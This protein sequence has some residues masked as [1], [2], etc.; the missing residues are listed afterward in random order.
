[1]RNG[2]RISEIPRI[3]L[4]AEHQWIDAEMVTQRVDEIGLHVFQNE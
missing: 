2:P 1:M 3:H 4:L